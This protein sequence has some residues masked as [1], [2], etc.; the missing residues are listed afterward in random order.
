MIFNKKGYSNYVIKRLERACFLAYYGSFFLLICSLS[1]IAFPIAY[2]IY[3]NPLFIIFL[4]LSIV[5]FYVFFLIS[6]VLESK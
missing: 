5:S 4:G 2:G 1:G 3:L 6:E